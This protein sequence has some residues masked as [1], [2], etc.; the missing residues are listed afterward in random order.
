MVTLESPSELPG[1]QVIMN[2][3]QLVAEVIVLGLFL[4]VALFGVIWLVMEYRDNN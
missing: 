1:R 4:A 3:L 2:C